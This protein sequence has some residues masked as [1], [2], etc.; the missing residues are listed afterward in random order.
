M[1]YGRARV[2]KDMW[3]LLSHIL[4]VTIEWKHGVC[5]Y[6]TNDQSEKANL[7]NLLHI[8]IMYAIFK[9]NSNRSKKYTI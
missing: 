7:S 2:F 9:N 5:D 1:L 8:L 3:E 4:N 6:I